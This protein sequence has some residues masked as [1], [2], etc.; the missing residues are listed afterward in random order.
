MKK[1]NILFNNYE[2]QIG[3]NIIDIDEHEKNML[4]MDLME[5]S[6]IGEE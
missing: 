4:Q 5:E 1:K 3:N 6:N 2:N